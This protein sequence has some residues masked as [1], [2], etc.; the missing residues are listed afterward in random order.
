MKKRIV[1]NSIRK[2]YNE[3]VVLN[4][5]SYTFEQDYCYVIE[6][7]SGIGKST[8]LNALS[9]YISIDDGD[10]SKNGLIV[11]Y[12]FQEEMLFSNL[13]VREN[14]MLKLYAERSNSV[15]NF[16]QVTSKCIDILKKFDMDSMLERKVNSL[17]GG[18]KQRIILAGMILTEADVLLL[19]E[20][21]T[22]LDEHNRER[23]LEMIEQYIE[24]HI[25]IIVSHIPLFLKH[26]MISL[27]MKDGKVYEKK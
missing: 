26:N 8:L 12:M 21:I 15:Y 6:G 2:K 18:E 27:K 11:D 1:I 7:K 17:S 13:T 19:D 24:G 3:K 9:D 22:S 10:I 25:I 4:D 14:L 16:E 20:P 23:F 5:L